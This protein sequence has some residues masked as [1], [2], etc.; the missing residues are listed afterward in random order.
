MSE[1]SRRRRV[2]AATTLRFESPA[3]WTNSRLE[4][5]RGP[6]TEGCFDGQPYFS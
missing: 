5:G 4:I 1:R 2:H 6:R 3:G